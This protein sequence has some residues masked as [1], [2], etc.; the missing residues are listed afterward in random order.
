MFELTSIVQ[1]SIMESLGIMVSKYFVIVNNIYKYQRSR[2]LT[3]SNWGCKI[4]VPTSLSCM[5]KL[6]WNPTQNDIF[7]TVSIFSRLK[8]LSPGFPHRESGKRKRTGVLGRLMMII[9]QTTMVMTMTTMMKIILVD[10]SAF[11]ADVDNADH[12]I[13]RSDAV[14][15]SGKIDHEWS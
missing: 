1:L 13:K 10:V 9:L 3:L 12:E 7:N 2:L 14:L 6:K 11:P 15:S 8:T 5:L 4:L